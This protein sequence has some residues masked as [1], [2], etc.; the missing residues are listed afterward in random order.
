MQ[1]KETACSAQQQPSHQHEVAESAVGDD[2]I[3]RLEVVEQFAQQAQLMLMF[4]AFGVIEQAAAAQ[5]ED[6]HN[7]QQGKTPARLLRTRLRV[8]PLVLRGVGQREGA[9]VDDFGAQAMPEWLDFRQKP[10]GAGRHRVANALEAVQGQAEAGLTVSAGAVIDRALVV[11]TKQGLDLPDHL[12]AGTGRIERLLEEAPKGATQRKDAVATVGPLLGLREQPG[13]N[14]PFQMQE[15][16]LA[17]VLDAP[18]QGRQARA[19]R[20][21]VR[22]IEHKSGRYT[23]PIDAGVTLLFMKKANASASAS[24]AQWKAQYQHCRQSLAAVGWISE[25]YVQDRGPGAGGPC[26]QWTRKVRGKTVSVAL[27]REQYEWLREAIQNWRQVQET[28]RQMQRL[29]RLALF[30]TVPHP[31]RRKRLG[32]KVLGLI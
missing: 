13:W 25:G 29:S 5:A 11:Q 4:V 28:L 19:P 26:Y 21:E 24:L 14:E 22:S 17:D 18:D 30:T 9:P 20:R 27:S 31:P 7:L 23:A 6:A 12:P 16:L 15:A 10:L 2:Q 1:T 3:A 32:K 8:S